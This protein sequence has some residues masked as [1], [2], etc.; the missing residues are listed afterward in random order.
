M[1]PLQLI[2]IIGHGVGLLM[3]VIGILAQAR[4]LRRGAGRVTPVVLAGAALLLLTGLGLAT[5]IALTG[6][7]N[8]PKLAIKFVIALAIFI[9][10][11]VH[12]GRDAS[13]PMLLGMVGLTLVNA[14]IAV[15]W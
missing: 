4:L 13:T 6:T 7:P 14:A 2:L 3:V 8:W 12:R 9:G 11:I 1:D 15:A 5:M 10:L